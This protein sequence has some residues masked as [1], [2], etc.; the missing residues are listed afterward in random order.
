MSVR[1]ICVFCGSSL[2]AKAAYREAA[3]Q[4]GQAI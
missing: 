1:R 2:G 4:T 3:V